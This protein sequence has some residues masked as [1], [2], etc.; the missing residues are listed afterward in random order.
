M[1]RTPTIAMGNRHALLIRSAAAILLGLSTAASVPAAAPPAAD[2]AVRVGAEFFLNRTETADSVAR[3]FRLMKEHGLSIARIFVIWNDIERTPGR[4]DFQRYDWV[5]DAAAANGI[6]IAATLCA[7]DPPGW[8]EQTS[9]YH[10]RTDLNEPG[11]RAHAAEYLD[12]V[13]LRYRNHPG[14]GYWLL[15]N[16][17]TL[18][19]CFTPTMMGRFAAWLQGRYGTVDRLNARWFRPLKSFADVRLDPTQWNQGWMDYPSYVDWKEFNIDNLCDQL[20]WIGDRVRQL[21][22]HHPTH[23]NPHGLLGCLPAVGQDL[24]REA[25]TVDFLGASMH[26][27]WHFGDFRR[28]EFGVAY[29]CCVD[30]LRSVSHGHPWW[31]TEL[32]GGPTV[33]TGKRAMTPTNAEITR[34]LWDAVGGGAKAVVFWLWNHRT[35]GREGGEWSLVGLDGRPTDRLAAIKD[36][37]RALS[38]LPVLERAVP[39]RSRVA[40]LYCRPTLLLGDMEGQNVGHQKDSLLSLWGCYRALLESHIP[41]DFVDVDELKA[42]RGAD[43]DV[44]YLPNCYA[45][46]AQTAVAIR[47]F[48]E[49]GGTVWADGLLGWKDPYGDMARGAPL[50]MASLF[51]FEFHDIEAT[52]KPF[53]LT[54]RADTG[55][56]LWQIGLTLRGAEATLCDGAGKPLSTTHRFGRGVA[57]YYATAL[58]LGYFRR[59]QAEVRRLI[60]APAVGHNAVLPVEMKGGSE[61]IVFRGMVAPSARVAILGNWGAKSTP[62]VCFAGNFHR[63]VEALSGAELKP[64]P[65]GDRTTVDVRLEAGAVAVVVAE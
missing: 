59:P 21:D 8:T 12:K 45:M 61:Q 25:K 19:P 27:P 60:V 65:E 48:A 18:P 63:V 11:L 5:Y 37:A 20:R 54:G 3:H 16:E 33:F 30:Q 42:G 22:P 14:Q 55:G 2:N 23:A 10:Q 1:P 31:V 29:A 15:M 28:D 13:V 58:S 47:R 57:Q 49:A 62:T 4:W 24:W 36:F 56:E 34:W 40:I 7:E 38:V 17:P 39:Q 41:A 6:R 32:Q 51:G 53:S 64:R 35:N 50:E 26:P 52:E 44:L 46:D 43:Y 9:F